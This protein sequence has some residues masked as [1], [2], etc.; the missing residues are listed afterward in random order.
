MKYSYLLYG[1]TAAELQ[2]FR[3]DTPTTRNISMVFTWIFWRNS[4]SKERREHDKYCYDDAVSFDDLVARPIRP[5]FGFFFR[6]SKKL[7]FS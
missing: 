6:G 5:F 3:E 1:Y 2:G 4:F 7:F